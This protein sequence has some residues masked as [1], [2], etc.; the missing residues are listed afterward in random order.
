MKCSTIALVAGLALCGAAFANPKVPQ[1]H[2]GTANKVE[3]VRVAKIQRN[4]DGTI[5]FL[6]NWI[7][8]SDLNRSER[9]AATPRFDAFG[10]TQGA[11][12]DTT[13]GD[14]APVGNTLCDGSVPFGSRWW[15]GAAAHNPNSA[16]DMK[17]DDGNATDGGT[18]E[19]WDMA[20]AWTN[21]TGAEECLMVIFPSNVAQTDADLGC[22][23]P[24]TDVGAGIVISFGVLASGAGYYY[25][26][27]DGLSGLGTTMPANGGYIQIIAS[28]VDETGITLA[29]G[30]TQPMLWGTSE[31]YGEAGRNT[32]VAGIARVDDD[33]P[34]DGILDVTAECYG[35]DFGVC[36]D[37]LQAANAFW[38]T[39]GGSG[40]AA[41]FDG[42][43][44][45]DF[46]DFDAYVA[47][48]EDALACPPGKTADFD[49]DGFIDFFDFDAYVAA[50]EQGC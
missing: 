43:G 30:P 19:R 6:T 7:D 10:L 46:F 4:A 9:G 44:F 25:A 12:L 35:Y 50:F 33:N 16:D 11:T 26:N 37:P 8:Y 15:F 47:C 5:R 49:G 21:G 22:D 27:V 20:W 28:V 23:D 2:T 48:F 29:T 45:V 32:G 40:C 39:G 31:D 34:L 18:L 13:D 42:D 3:P 14:D 41:D 1:R 38:I 24:T 36:P 17:L